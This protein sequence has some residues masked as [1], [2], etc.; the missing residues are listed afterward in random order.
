MVLYYQSSYTVCSD[1]IKYRYKMNSE[2]ADFTQEGGGQVVFTSIG[3]LNRWFFLRFCAFVE[4][5]KFSL[6]TNDAI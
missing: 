5:R 1:D 3:D 6:G 2:E 4:G